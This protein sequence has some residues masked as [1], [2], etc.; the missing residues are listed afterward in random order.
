MTTANAFIIVFSTIDS[1]SFQAISNYKCII[2][3]YTRQHKIHIGLVGTKSDLTHLREVQ[4]SEAQS[5]A[6]KNGWTYSECSAAYDLNV[7][8]LFQNAIRSGRGDKEPTQSRKLPD[9][10]PRRKQSILNKLSTHFMR[11]RSCSKPVETTTDSLENQY[12]NN[13][14]LT[15]V[16]DV[17]QMTRRRSYSYTT[18]I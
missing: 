13:N 1:K 17:R 6:T 16:K 18:M 9:K 14:S 8:S 4:R 3:Q 7:Q 10:H 12:V 15:V 2:E 5:Y 11:K